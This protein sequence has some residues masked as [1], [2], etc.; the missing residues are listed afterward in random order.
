MELFI[1]LFP[2]ENEVYALY[3]E[4]ESIRTHGI[5]LGSEGVNH[6]TCTRTNKLVD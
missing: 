2:S 1:N 5:V 4:E 3:L 6:V